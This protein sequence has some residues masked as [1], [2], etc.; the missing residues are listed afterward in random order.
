MLRYIFMGIC[1]NMLL[2]IPHEVFHIRNGVI[3]CTKIMFFYKNPNQLEKVFLYVWGKEYLLHWNRPLILGRKRFRSSSPV[4]ARL[5]SL[6]V[7]IMLTAI[8]SRAI[9]G[10]SS[11]GSYFIIYFYLDFMLQRYD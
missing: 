7:S 11:I 6:L 3:K 4:I 9:C 1:M 5:M 8:V 10:S 2:N